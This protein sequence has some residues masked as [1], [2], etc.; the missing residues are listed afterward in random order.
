MGTEMSAG[1]GLICFDLPCGWRTETTA[2]S[3]TAHQVLVSPVGSKSW[4]SLEAAA[5]A[6][7]PSA[8]RGD[9][10]P[11]VSYQPT[12]AAGTVRAGTGRTPRR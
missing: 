1:H 3:P 7:R 8:G 9:L 5:T 6:S 12:L 4:S 10:L 2:I 11:A